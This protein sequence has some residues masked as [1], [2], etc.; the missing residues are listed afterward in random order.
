VRA[1]PGTHLALLA[2]DAALPAIIVGDIDLG[3]VFASLLPEGIED[4]IAY[5][6]LN[7]LIIVG[8]EDSVNEF[9]DLLKMI[10]RKPQQVIV[11]LQAVQVSTELTKQM[12]IQWYYILGNT[13]IEPI[14][15]T[16]A[17]SIQIGYTPPGSP[18]FSA[19]LTYILSTGK[20]RL[21]DAVRVHTMNLLPAYNMS[22]IS[23]PVVQV[24]GVAGGGLAGEGVQ[25][26]NITYDYLPTILYIVPQ[27]L[28]DGTITM[29]V[30]FSRSVAT[31]FVPVP[32]AGYGTYEAPIVTTSSIYAT[33]NVRDGE[34]FVVGGSVQKT[35]RETSQRLPLLSDIPIV[36]DFLFNR[37]TY[38]ESEQET[39]LFITPRIVKEEA[40]PAT[41]GPI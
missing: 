41:L 18:D 16:T 27:I 17:A 36:G 8:T 25:T 22:V 39:L 12:G 9:I 6:M 38:T 24:G 7:A 3:G 11:E 10:D 37:K 26:I 30:P 20:G 15:M 40:A 35:V 21:V 32:L 28:G 13:T 23:Y 34:T 14:G 33:V 19:T 1:A 4:M 29:S 2:H 5:P 31:G